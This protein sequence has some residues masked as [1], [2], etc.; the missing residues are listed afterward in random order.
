[1][2]PAAWNVLTVA[3][4]AACWGAFLLTWL[5]GA[6]YNQSRAPEESTRTP[7][8]S[9]WAVAAILVL[10]LRLLPRGD[11][12]SW[13]VLTPWVRFLGLA[14]LIASTAFTLWARLAL[15]IMWSGSPTVKQEHQLRTHGPYGVTRHPIY[16]GMLGMV[17][18]GVLL[19]GLGRWVLIFPVLVVFLEVKIHTEER[20]MLATFPEDYPRYRQQVPQ[21]VPGAHLGRRRRLADS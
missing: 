5:A 2:T 15:G 3:A 12:H 16:S 10:I 21:L 20:L 4:I 9:A 7:W 8:V 11:F 18:G 14:I 13:V 17:L 19:A 1:V 6:I